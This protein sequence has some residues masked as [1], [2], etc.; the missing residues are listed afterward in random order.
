MTIKDRLGRT[1]L[2]FRAD[3]LVQSIQN[4]DERQ[5]KKDIAALNQYLKDIDNRL[6]GTL[7]PFKD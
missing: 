1:F 4:D 6:A 3:A 5:L 2:R 7:P